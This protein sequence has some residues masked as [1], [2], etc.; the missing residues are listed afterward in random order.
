MRLAQELIKVAKSILFSI[1]LVV[2]CQGQAWPENRPDFSGR[3]SFLANYAFDNNDNVLAGG[4]YIPEIA[5]KFDLADNHFLDY[6]ASVNI[7][8]LAFFDTLDHSTTQADIAPYRIWG[9]YSGEQYELRIGLQKINFGSASI[10][11]PLMWFDK[12]DARDPLQLTN[13]VY[14]ALGRYFFLN[15]ANVWAWILY[16]NDE[17]R[18]WDV[19][20]GCKSRPEYGGRLQ[21]PVL[22]GELA[23]SFH[24]KTINAGKLMNSEAFNKVPETRLALDGKWDVKVGF[25]FETTWVHRSEDLGIYT[26]KSMYNVGTDYTFGMGNGLNIAGEHLVTAFDKHGLGFSRTSHITA[27]TLSYPLGLDDNVS[28]VLSYNWELKHAS[29]FLNYEHRF[30]KFTGYIMAYYTP[31]QPQSVEK[32]DLINDLSG[33]GFRIMIVY[34]Y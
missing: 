23:L 11:R 2:L 32:E 30:D 34:D 29:V 12:M 33:P 31:E 28:T 9:R 3:F 19:M 13:G 25:W 17:K 20:P 21:Y 16:G 15:N 14:G 22:D 26:N 4:R 27:A 24:H 18:G 10:L 7:S 5:Q 8:V 6:E 1:G